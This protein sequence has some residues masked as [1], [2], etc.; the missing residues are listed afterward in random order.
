MFLASCYAVFINK[1]YNVTTEKCKNVM[2]VESNNFIWMQE[3]S[4][5]PCQAMSSLSTF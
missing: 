4:F 2:Y 3:F 5:K 1:Q